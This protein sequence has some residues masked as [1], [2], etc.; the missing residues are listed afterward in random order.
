MVKAE[1]ICWY[2]AGTSGA[3]SRQSSWSL[4][5][6]WVTFG[7]VEYC[8][9]LPLCP[10]DDYG[11]SWLV[12]HVQKGKSSSLVIDLGE[13]S[14]QMSQ[15]TTRKYPQQEW[16]LWI[17]PKFGYP[18]G[19]NSGIEVQA[20]RL[21]FFRMENHRGAMTC[22]QISIIFVGSHVWWTDLNYWCLHPIDFLRT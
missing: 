18:H 13:G 4:Q 3:L 9:F 15:A 16:W 5:Q 1:A 6:W 20:N 2:F 10:Q 14:K 17:S 19:H 11:F 21:S 7:G 8:L 12:R 22:A